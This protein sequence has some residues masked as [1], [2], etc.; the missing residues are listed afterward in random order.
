MK[1][2][3]L[4]LVATL[5][6]SVNAEVQTPPYCV[7]PP[8]K[9]HKKHKVIPPKAK[10]EYVYVYVPV[11]G[12][13]TIVNNIYNEPSQNRLYGILGSGPTGIETTIQPGLYQ[14]RTIYGTIWGLGY[15]R[16]IQ[17]F[18]FGFMA[19]SN[20]TTAMTLGWGF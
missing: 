9:L 7:Q 13:K 16:S 5:S 10:V 17:E 1:K 19:L 6:L 4:L 15:Q 2:Y 8:K 20:Y 11:E 3:I 14:F 18:N 12:G